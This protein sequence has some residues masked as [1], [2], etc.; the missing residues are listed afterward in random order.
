MAVFRKRLIFWLIKAYVKRWGKVITLSFILGLLIF[1][2]LA[3]GSKHILAM[4]PTEKKERIGVIGA[5][6]ADNLPFFITSNISRG[7]TKIAPDGSIQP[8]IAKRW[9]VTNNGRTYT[10]HLDTSHTFSDGTP[11][12]SKELG[13][14]FANVKIDTNKD[15]AITFH[16]KDAYSPFL[17][18]VSRP[19][20]KQGYI[21]IGNYKLSGIKLNGN[22]V[23][24]LD[25]TSTKDRFYARTYV[26]YP[27][28]ESLKHA[29]AL[30]EITEAKG[31]TNQKY[32]D[33]TFESYP[34]AKVTRSIDYTKLVTLF[35]NT[36]DPFLSDKKVR[37]AL[38]YALPNSFIH[39]ERT[40]VP[41]P[42][43]SIY[44]NPDV[45][46]RSQDLEHAKLLLDAATNAASASAMPEV[47]ITTA[48][49]YITVA[50][51]VAKTWKN[52]G[53]KV[54][55]TENESIPSSFQIYLGDFTLP[56]DPDQYVL[57]HSISDDN[58][59]K[60]RSQRLDKLLED[61]RSLQN[62][63]ERRKIYYDFQKYMLDESPAAFLYFPYDYVVTRK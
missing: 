32:R 30:G 62:T 12:T 28:E 4:L 39:G 11:V 59:T 43:T 58:I 45:I 34:T 63:D 8:D 3:L 56:R 50:D 42:P 53:L 41:Y 13:Y 29:F 47:T 21:G 6:T 57:W 10:F 51:E 7:L 26:F 14:K 36:Q 16:L 20:F 55:I 48:K 2:G 52:M 31:L 25:I 22:F 1:F 18:T 5:Y 23:E 35:F 17:V 37:N 9:D 61:G 19:I 24:S 60:L 49:R 40:V 33:V 54:K 46:N 27:S 15:D 44:I 38:T